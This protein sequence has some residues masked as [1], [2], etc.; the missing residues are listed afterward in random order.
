M[1]GVAGQAGTKPAEL[2]ISHNVHVKTNPPGLGR[3]QGT[4]GACGSLPSSLSREALL[5]VWA[6][7]SERVR[8]GRDLRGHLVQGFR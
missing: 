2:S 7:Q 1:T 5:V 8:A 4:L 3:L 6:A